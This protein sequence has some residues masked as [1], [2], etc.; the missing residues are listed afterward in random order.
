MSDI[1]TI[2]HSTYN[3][4]IFIGYLKYHNIDTIVDV[5]STPYSR[6]ANQFNKE[7]LHSALIKENIFYIYMGDSL[8]ARYIEKDLLFDDGKADFSKIVCTTKFKKGIDR[9]EVGIEK[10]YK[11]A[12]MC[13]EK[14]PVECHRFSLL[15]NYIFNK[16]FSIS[17]LFQEKKLE[18]ILLQNKLLDYYNEN[19]KLTTDIYKLL[20][21]RIMQSSL[22]D[23]KRLDIKSLYLKLNKMIGYNPF[24]NKQEVV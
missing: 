3:I 10:G 21:L 2:G 15:S 16:G 7:L 17:H 9:L 23:V 8:G 11:I 5:R 18:H 1:Y 14:N 19:G 12:L 4:E 20:N 22:F 6:F 24:E 13:S